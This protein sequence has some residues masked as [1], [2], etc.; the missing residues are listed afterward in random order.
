MNYQIGKTSADK[1]RVMVITII[2]IIIIINNIIIIIII[3][4]I[5]IIITIIINIITVIIKSSSPSSTWMYFYMQP[6]IYSPWF[7]EIQVRWLA[8]LWLLGLVGA[9][10]D[11]VEGILK[12]SLRAFILISPPRIDPWPLLPTGGDISRLD[13]RMLSCIKAE[14]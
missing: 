5:I 9:T 7:V 3:I 11:G 4:N 2:F 6:N 13:A 8:Q 14:I 1:K 10:G 12:A